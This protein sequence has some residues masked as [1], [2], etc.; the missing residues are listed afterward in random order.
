MSVKI[1]VPGDMAAL[2]VGDGCMTTPCGFMLP[3][4]RTCWSDELPM[5]IGVSGEPQPRTN[6]LCAR[7][8]LDRA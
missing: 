1:F 2:S 7:R 6:S 4:M 8:P 5:M 3:G